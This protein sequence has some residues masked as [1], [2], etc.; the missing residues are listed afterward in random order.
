MRTLAY[1]AIS[2]VLATA[3]VSGCNDQGV[4]SE[5]EEQVDL[6]SL[7]G[8]WEKVYSEQIIKLNPG[9][10]KQMLVIE[11][12]ML[13]SMRGDELDFKGRITLDASKN[14]KTLDMELAEDAHGYKTGE[15]SKGIYLIKGDTLKWCNAAPGA[16]DRPTDFS[17]NVEKNHILLVFKRV[18]K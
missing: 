13:T 10:K 5:E 12:D 6:E 9:L 4:H 3:F 1:I 7:Q 17:N 15:I 14:P 2:G 16:D 18:K 11:G 8:N